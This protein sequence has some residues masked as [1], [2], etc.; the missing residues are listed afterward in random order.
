MH[1]EA[2]KQRSRVSQPVSLKEIYL[3]GILFSLKVGGQGQK[4]LKVLVCA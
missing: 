1:K 3:R 2:L 4:G